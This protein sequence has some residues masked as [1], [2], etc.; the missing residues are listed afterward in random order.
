MRPG[1]DTRI[2]GI[3]LL[4]AMVLVPLAAAIGADDERQEVALELQ[5]TFTRV[6]GKISPSVVSI[7]SLTPIRGTDDDSST[8]SEGGQ[9]ASGWIVPVEDTR[10][11]GHTVL[12]SASGFVLDARRGIIAT[13]RSA[14]LGRDGQIPAA[15]DV[16]GHDR[17]HVMASMLGGEPTLDLLFLKITVPVDGRQPELAAI[18]WGESDRLTPGCWAFLAGDPPGIDTFFAATLLSGIPRRDCYQE[19]LQASYLQISQVIHPQALG[20]PVTDIDGA[21]VGMLVPRWDQPRIDPARQ[22]VQFALPS[23][24]IR[25]IAAPIIHQRS[26]ESPW[27]G[28]SVMSREELREEIGPRALSQMKRPPVGIYIENVFDPSP[29]FEAGI[30]PGDFLTSFNGYPINSPIEFQKQFYLAGPRTVAELET[31][32]NGTIRRSVLTIQTR[33][34]EARVTETDAKD[35]RT[36]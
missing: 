10:Y 31:F 34:P 15:F 22:V 29:A 20:G 8:K 23:K 33:P 25:E 9:E 28:F 14:L 30:R 21:V 7:R 5:D 3:L 27:L 32:R 19:N 4:G 1:P 17:I 2:R 6:H 18:T 24:I 35:S 12:G 16:E 26:V 13:T 11:P 36:E